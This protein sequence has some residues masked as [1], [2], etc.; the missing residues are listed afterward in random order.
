M[1]LDEFWRHCRLRGRRFAAHRCATLMKSQHCS[2]GQIRIFHQVAS[3][4]QCS[5]DRGSAEQPRRVAGSVPSTRGTR[6]WAL[7]PTLGSMPHR[8][9]TRAR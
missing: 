2:I 7:Q 1:L 6:L 5:S 8:A 3:D 4:A 9:E